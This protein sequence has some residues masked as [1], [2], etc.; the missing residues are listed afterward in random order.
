[1]SNI[2]VLDHQGGTYR[3]IFHVAVP[4][5][6]NSAGVAWNTALLNSLKGGTSVLK[7]G[8]GS[9]GTIAAAEL[10]SIQAGNTLEIVYA[11]N[12][13]AAFEG[14]SGAAQQADLDALYS[15]IT[16]GQLT[17]LSAQLKWWG[18]TLT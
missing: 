4:V 11:F 3:L 7:S 8:D 16:G 5:G 9:A 1:M 13:T 14:E 15:F 10:S 12:P 17:A 18:L 6:N 2:H